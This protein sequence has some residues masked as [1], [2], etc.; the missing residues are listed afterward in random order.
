MSQKNALLIAL[1]VKK[2]CLRK[3]LSFRS[4]K[5]FPLNDY[6]NLF[7]I[8]FAKNY[9]IANAI[10]SICELWVKCLAAVVMKRT[11]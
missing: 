1:Q 3:F 7:Y 8:T 11:Q 2:G 5:I 9:V 6:R 10:C 4:N